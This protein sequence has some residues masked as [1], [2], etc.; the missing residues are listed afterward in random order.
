[1]FST[2]SSWLGLP[3]TSKVQKDLSLWLGTSL[4]LQHLQHSLA[5]SCILDF[6]LVSVTSINQYL[7]KKCTAVAIKNVAKVESLDIDLLPDHLINPGEYKPPFHTP[8]MH[9]CYCWANRKEKLV[10]R[11]KRKLTS[12]YTYDSLIFDILF[13]LKLETLVVLSFLQG[14]TLW[15]WNL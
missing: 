12:L 1:M 6:Q 9:T 5:S 11:A 2:W 4:F 10:S 14:T 13:C 7:K 3:L 15:K 8:H